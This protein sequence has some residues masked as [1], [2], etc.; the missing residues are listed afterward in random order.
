MGY[1]DLSPMPISKDQRALETIINKIVIARDR[2]KEHLMGLS[3]LADQIFGPTPQ[4]QPEV[5][6]VNPPH[7]LI[8]IIHDE[9]QRLENIQADISSQIARLHNL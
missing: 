5:N 9:L 4:A 3:S 1:A 7:A 2:A 6:G 8:D